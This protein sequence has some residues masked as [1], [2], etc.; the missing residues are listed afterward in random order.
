MAITGWIYPSNIGNFQLTKF[1]EE[2]EKFK[3]I[4]D[5]KK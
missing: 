3:D 1:K 2:I 5:L 4:K